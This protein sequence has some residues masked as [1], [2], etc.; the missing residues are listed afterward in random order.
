MICFA[1]LIARLSLIK[2]S[3]KVKQTRACVL[4]YPCRNNVFGIFIDLS[5]IVRVSFIPM[6]R[7]STAS[8]NTII[9]MYLSI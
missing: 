7:L 4:I 8:N 2:G 1:F 5:E 6:L 3:S 9:S